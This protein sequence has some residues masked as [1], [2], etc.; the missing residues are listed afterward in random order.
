MTLASLFHYFLI[1][2][3][4]VSSC[5]C[6]MIFFTFN[7]KIVDFSVLEHYNPGK[8]TLLLDDEGNEWARFE[9]DRREPVTID[10]MPQHLLHAFIAAEDHEFY[11][12]GGISWKGIIR[13]L[14][15][16]LYH[17]KRIQGASTITQQLVKLLF[18][19]SKKTFERKIKEQFY[20]LLVERQFSK[21]QILEIYLNHL[22]FGSGIYGVEAACQRFWG[23]EVKDISISQSA[24]LAGIIRSPLNYCPLQF[25]F[26]SMRRRNIVLRSMKK[27]GAITNE[28]YQQATMLPLELREKKNDDIAPH[29]KESLRQQL[30]GMVGR[31][32]LY[33]GGLIIQTSL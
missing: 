22:Y 20:A 27:I 4:L 9:L 7:T 19:H 28:E 5:L 24:T 17:G 14:L 18:F 26:S 1:I 25:P 21:E 8:P 33:S 32:T 12:H 6:G 11:N 13:S 15:I 30:E 31:K 23:I 3:I 16:N 29:L 10:K 2:L